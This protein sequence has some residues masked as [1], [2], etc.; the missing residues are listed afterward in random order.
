MKLQDVKT[1]SSLDQWMIPLSMETKIELGY[2]TLS[3]DITGNIYNLLTN[4]KLIK[5]RPRDQAS[6][7]DIDFYLKRGSA[8]V[9]EVAQMAPD[10]SFLLNVVFF[11]GAVIEIGDIE[12]GIDERI[13]S[14]CKKSGIRF[15]NIEELTTLLGY[16]CNFQFNGENYFMFL[17][18][19]AAETDFEE[20]F[21][22][23]VDSTDHNTAIERE[24]RQFS[25]CGERLR[26]PVEKRK[27]DKMKDIFFATRIIYKDKVIPD[28][29]VRLARGS[30]LFSDFTKTGQIRALAAGAMIELTQESGSFLK[31]WDQYGSIEGEIFMNKAKAIGAIEHNGSPEKTKNGVMFFLNEPPTDFLTQDDSIEL[32][33]E[34]P[35]YVQDSEM[36]WDR[37][38]EYIEKKIK[39]NSSGN[40][41]FQGNSAENSQSIPLEILKISSTSIELKLDAVPSNC[42]YLVW[43]TAGERSQIERRMRARTAIIEGRSAN[44]LLGLLIEEGGILPDVQRVSKLKPLTPFVKEKIFKNDPTEKQI[45]AIDI[46]LNTPDIALIQGPPGTGKTTVI[47]AILERLN[48]EYDK[49][50]S[51]RGKILVSGYQHDAVENIVSRLSVNSLP[52]VKFGRRSSDS[53]FTDDVSTDRINVWCT[54]VSEKIRI[55]APQI[56]QTEEQLK[57]TELFI[58]YTL[59]PSK[60]NTIHLINRVLN[61]PRSIVTSEITSQ[62]DDILN[63]IQ[64]EIIQI[65][66]I[67][68]RLIRSLRVKMSSFIDDGPERAMDLLTGLESLLSERECRILTLASKWKR[69]Q[70]LNFLPQLIE[71][72][73]DLLNRFNPVPDFKTEKPRED[74]LDL[75]SKVSSLLAEKLRSTNQQDAVLAEFV[76]ELE[77]NPEG[78]REAIEDYNL[79]F[80]ATTQYSGS[81]FMARVK[82]KHKNDAISYDTVIVDEAARTSPRD[83]LI[84]MALAEKRIILVGDH[85]QLPHL[86]DEEVARMLE[87]QESSIPGFDIGFIKK[88]MFEYLF[89]RLKKLEENDGVKRVVTLDAQYRTHPLLGDFVSNNF[90]H[91]YREGFRSP[92]PVNHFDHR[93][94]GIEGKA[95]VWLDVPDKLG[96]ES[97][98]GTS[99]ARSIEA[100]QIAKLL[101]EWINSEKGKGLSFG[102]ISFYKSQVNEVFKCLKEYGITEATQDGQWQVTHKYRYLDGTS[103]RLRIGTVDSFQG[104]EFDVVLLSMVRSIDVENPPHW[105]NKDQDIHKKHQRIFG[106][107]MSE[108]RLC[109]SMSRQKKVLVLVGNADLAR[110]TLG[111]EAVPALH[112]FYHLCREYGVVL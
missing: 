17:C 93:L 35:V 98:F 61:L 68:N 43:S 3:K 13:E 46:A 51:I 106:H 97:K 91:Q 79:I 28:A 80:A 45:E 29:A 72:K 92:L 102:V 73:Q 20:E 30:V 19:P 12:I 86:I 32:T 103:E 38:R 15:K 37:Y 5:I 21:L 62:A 83:L 95:A 81:E 1:P 23:E 77:N 26:V 65:D 87:Q 75:F 25:I 27:I 104:M 54:N 112:K 44:P 107:L 70:D 74:V 11:S 16:K 53:E 47:T 55:H 56:A 50:K 9:A 109:V 40:G 67:S 8:H 48:E 42:K 84:P 71:V 59:S 69:N 105:L 6:S 41:N 76:H 31:Q 100:I 88:S 60:N 99:R 85:R 66:P 24:Y 18:G 64:S 39:E 108:N 57:L 89:K 34:M 111:S 2:G 58:A 10:G 52:T 4:G 90:Y 82:T 49:S 78:L 36:T 110:S 101:D 14:T 94:K 63:S 22:G 33:E 96:K 7:N